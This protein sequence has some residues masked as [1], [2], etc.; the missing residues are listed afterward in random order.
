MERRCG[1]PCDVEPE[2]QE[3]LD[4]AEWQEAVAEFLGKLSTE[5]LRDA[6]KGRGYKV[7]LE[8]E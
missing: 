7:T 2:E 3:A 6:L 1:S 4:D 8:D 5:Q